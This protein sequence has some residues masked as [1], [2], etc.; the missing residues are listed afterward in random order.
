MRVLWLIPPVVA[1]FVSHS[2][3]EDNLFNCPL[4]SARLRMGVGANEWR[5][6]GN[7][8]DFRQP[9]EILGEP[10]LEWRDVGFC[11]VPKYVRGQSP[12]VWLN[13]CRRV[14]NKG[15][16]LIV[17]IC[18]YPFRENPI[19]IDEFYR[20]VLPLTDTLVVNSEQMATRMARHYKKKITVIEDA[21]LAPAE[22]PVFAPSGTLKL[23]WFG[24]PLNLRFLEPFVV[25]LLA[26]GPKPCKLVIV[27]ADG[28][29]AKELAQQIQDHHAPAVQAK[30]VEWSLES[31]REELAACD[32]SVLPADPFDLLK[33]GASAN[34][35]AEVINAGRFAVASPL[36]SYLPF[37]DAA[38]LGNNL[39]EG[40]RWAQANGAEVLQRIQRGQ[41]LVSGRF[42]LRK[43]GSQWCDLF[44]SAGTASGYLRGIRQFFGWMRS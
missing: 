38:W 25:E 4:A 12:A 43:I 2:G 32:M 37:A 28:F 24:H 41:G 5:H 44:D 27:T 9:F 29:G 22:Q 35:L 23:L 7:E 21:V 1:Q 15:C 14:K 3:N 31:T 42:T 40:I 17:D 30:F 33:G 13:A 6:Q 19:D 34:R 16:R 39:V 20:K 8:N 36:Q 18:D 26:S 11:V 10:S